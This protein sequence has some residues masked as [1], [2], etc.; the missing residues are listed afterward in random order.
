MTLKITEKMLVHITK[1]YLRIIY[2]LIL[3]FIV[4]TDYLDY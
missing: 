4:M 1:N 3:P 2:K